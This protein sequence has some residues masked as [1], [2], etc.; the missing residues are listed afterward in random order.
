MQCDYELAFDYA[1]CTAKLWFV[2][3][4][5]NAVKYVIKFILQIIVRLKGNYFLQVIDQVAKMF[6]FYVILH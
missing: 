1:V 2:V 5:F 4:L 6:Y 3:N